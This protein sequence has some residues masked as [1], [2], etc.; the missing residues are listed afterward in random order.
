MTTPEP[1]QKALDIAQRVH[2]DS[3]AK[4][5]FLFGSRARGDHRP[6]SDIDLLVV[7]KNDQ[8]SSWL[9]NLRQ[10]ARLIQKAKMPDASGIDILSMGE[11]EFRR[12]ARLRNNVANIAA[13][14]G[15]R[16]IVAE[17][18]SCRTEDEDEETDWDDVDRKMNDA[19]GA[20]DWISAIYEAGVIDLGDDRQYGTMAQHALEFAYK[21]VIAAHGHDYPTSG[22]DGHN[23]TLLAELLREH[24]I[25]GRNEQAPGENR[26]YLS[27]FGGAAAPAD[28]L[29]LDRRRIAQDI[30]AAVSRLRD[31]V[32]QARP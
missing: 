20:A 22:R 17:S 15:C 16:V 28:E 29:P 30:P 4:Q 3:G 12:R 8:H 24:R 27:E 26:R 23:L 19:N 5:T 11:E 18:L 31:L 7:T 1:D 21:A 2:R 25:I 6:D 14:E 10:R 32:A 13:K 9:E